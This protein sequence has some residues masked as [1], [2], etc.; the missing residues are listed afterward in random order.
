MSA[1]GELYILELIYTG[2]VF[3]LELIYTVIQY[4]T[5]NS[6]GQWHQSD[7][8]SCTCWLKPACSQPITNGSNSSS[9][10]ISSL[11]FRSR[12]SELYEKI[13]AGCKSPNR[14]NS[15]FIKM[16]RTADDFDEINNRTCDFFKY[17]IR[18]KLTAQTPKRSW[19]RRKWVQSILTRTA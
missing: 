15:V 5:R 2:E 10:V 19:L 3:I 11:R 8:G 1:S 9:A 17:A 6:G 13:G 18:S 4:Y 12:N 14:F 16:C 7:S